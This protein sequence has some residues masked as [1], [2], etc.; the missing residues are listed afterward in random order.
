M[1][2]LPDHARGYPYVAELASAYTQNAMRAPSYRDYIRPILR[3]LSEHGRESTYKR[4]LSSMVLRLDRDNPVEERENVIQVAFRKIGDPAHAPKW[5]PRPEATKNE[6]ENI[7]TARDT[8][9]NW[10]AQR[11]ITA[12]FDKVAMDE[13]R[14][15][16]WLQYA[17]FVTR[18][19]VF[20]DAGTRYKLRQDD[21][22]QQY[23]DQRFDRIGGSMS[24]L[25]MEIE[26]RVIV[27]F[28]ETGGACYVHREGSPSCPSFDRRYSH[29]RE[30]RIGT[31]FPLLMRYSGNN[32]RDVKGEGRFPHTHDWKRRLRW[33]IKRK[34]GIE[35]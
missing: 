26:D 24:A 28:G 30:L 7:E 9:N 35:A 33:W 22:I 20:G 31:D 21:R 18:F 14:R 5:Q 13:D 2:R 3:F 1:L 12:F 34:L 6:R 25:L 4:C 15:N 23:V 32:Y 29:I 27:E 16:F 11:F 17:P 8:L 10:I 19:K